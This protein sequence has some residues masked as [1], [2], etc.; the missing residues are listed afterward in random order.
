ME[1]K[2]SYTGFIL[3]LISFLVLFFTLPFL[4]I[5]DEALITRITLN[6]MTI[7]LVLLMYLIYKTEYI[8]WFNGTTYQEALEAGSQR[9][10]QFA[11]RHLLHF[12]I[13]SITSL[14][15]SSLLHIFHL[16]YWIDIVMICLGVII[17]A[18]ST[19]KIKL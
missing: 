15:I 19:I 14:I 17:T 13:F 16:A 11:Y 4:P 10:K 5:K 6:F 7:Y 12:G 2:K 3:W 9:R 18:F 8:Y 1:Y